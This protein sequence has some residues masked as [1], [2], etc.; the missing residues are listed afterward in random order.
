MNRYLEGELVKVTATFDGENDQPADPTTVA[1]KYAV[2]PISSPY[3]ST[4]T[5][6]YT[7]ADQP[8]PGIIARL[9]VG[10]YEVQVDSTGQ[11]GYWLY[12]VVSTGAVQT[13]GD[14]WAVVDPLPL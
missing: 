2:A 7:G 13:S 11:P 1:F 14:G 5:L 12:E 6:T 3:G 8:G 4:V 9:G 10:V